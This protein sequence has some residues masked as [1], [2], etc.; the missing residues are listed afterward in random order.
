MVHPDVG[1]LPQK[2]ASYPPAANADN[3]ANSAAGILSKMS[4]AKQGCNISAM[5]ASMGGKISGP[6]GMGSGSFSAQMSTLKKSGCQTLAAVIGNFNNSVYQARC[7]I[8]N[9]STNSTTDVEIDQSANLN[10]LGAGSLI[11]NNCPGGAV[12]DQSASITAKV[13]TKISAQT[14]ENI[15]N[16]VQQGLKNT[17]D[18]V[19]K[20]KEGYQGTGSGVQALT[21]IHQQL[22]NASQSNEIYNHIV[23]LCNKFSI[24]QSINANAIAGGQII[25]SL[26]CKWSATAVLDL[27]LAN[28]VSA[29]YSSDI[30]STIAAFM[31][32]K[33]SQKISVV[34]KSVPCV[35]CDM[36]SDNTGMIIG[37]VVAIIVVFV[38]IKFA[39]SK[40]G[41]ALSGNLAS[42]V[43]KGANSALAKS[44]IKGMA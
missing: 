9:D 5:N 42:A 8:Q 30:T 11:S 20:V 34:E 39:K 23:K 16:V 15:A 4:A 35:V 44:V 31:S 37:I 40:K 13:I 41:S 12:W 17:A 43:G 33:E 10:S 38:I 32:S 3:A 27:Q 36:F 2:C 29:A 19:G 14:S 18:N 22:T 28:I 25:N 6:L 1:N 7:M 26:P 24:N 21:S